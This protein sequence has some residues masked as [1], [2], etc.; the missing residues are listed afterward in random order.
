MWNDFLDGVGA[1]L[2][3]CE[4]YGRTVEANLVGLRDL[5][6]GWGKKICD[7]VVWHVWSADFFWQGN[8]WSGHKLISLNIHRSRQSAK[9]CVICNCLEMA[10]GQKM[11]AAG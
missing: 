10:L 9:G 11:R 8:Q 6:P 3:Q 7:V 2:P 1:I 4:E 5:S